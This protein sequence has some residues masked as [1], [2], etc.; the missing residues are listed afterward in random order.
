MNFCTRCG[1]QLADGE[2]CGCAMQSQQ[3]MPQPVTPVQ[4]QQGMVSPMGVQPQQQAPQGMYNQTKQAGASAGFIGDILEF[5]KNVFKAPA[6][7]VTTY[8]NKGSWLGGIVL[9]AVCAVVTML[10]NLLYKIIVNARYESQVLNNF[11]IWDSSTWTFDP[12]YS[13][14]EIVLGVFGDLIYTFASAAVMAGIMYVLIKFVFE[15][16][17]TVKMSQLFALMALVAAIKLPFSFVYT[18]LR[19]IPLTFFST[20]GSWISTFGSAVG[21]ITLIVGLK[22][23]VK[24]DNS[25]FLVYAGAAFVN[26]IAYSFLDLIGLF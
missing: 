6:D 18:V 22:S 20:V 14:W 13:T 3:G 12:V 21:V 23:K 9:L 16:D 1:K 2:V 26:A 17:S 8:V 7:A 5:F 4:P 19:Y 10:S 25:L 11:N 24:Y 15:K